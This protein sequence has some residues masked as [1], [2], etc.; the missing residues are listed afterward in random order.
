MGTASAIGAITDR[1]A[2]I[3]D[4]SRRFGRGVIALLGHLDRLP[5]FRLDA[6]QLL[7][8]NS[9]VLYVGA[10]KSSGHRV[11]DDAAILQRMKERC[12]STEIR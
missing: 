6:S 5:S 3:R 12:H 11:L 2:M 9:T 7:Q 1:L 8:V 10:M 4:A